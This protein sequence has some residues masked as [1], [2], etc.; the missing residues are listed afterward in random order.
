MRCLVSLMRQVE[1]EERIF[2]KYSRHGLPRAA[3]G[4][5]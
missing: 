1:K 3:R 4:Y 2:E 5:H